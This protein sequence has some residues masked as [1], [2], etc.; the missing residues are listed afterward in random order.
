MLSI[1]WDLKRSVVRGKRVG[2]WQSSLGASLIVRLVAKCDARSVL[3]VHGL[4]SR[5]PDV[6]PPGAAFFFTGSVFPSNPIAFFF[7][8]VFLVP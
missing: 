3:I 2:I 8:N 7:S 5:S 6:T 4:T 1:I